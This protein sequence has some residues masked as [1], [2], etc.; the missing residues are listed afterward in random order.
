MMHDQLE[1]VALDCRQAAV[2]REAIA[3]WPRET[4]ILRQG[5]RVVHDSEMDR[6]EFFA[7]LAL[8]VVLTLTA[9]VV[10]FLLAAF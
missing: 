1:P 7:I 5:A 4:I 8:L 2:W 10:F 6:P 9:L 3:R